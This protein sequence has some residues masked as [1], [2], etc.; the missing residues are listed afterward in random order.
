MC[1]Q[2]SESRGSSRAGSDG[3]ARRTSCCT[4]SRTCRTWKRAS[5]GAWVGRVHG[6]HGASSKWRRHEVSSNITSTGSR[7]SLEKPH[8]ADCAPPDDQA[9]RFQ[10]SSR[11]HIVRPSCIVRL[12]RQQRQGSPAAAAAGT[13]ASALQLRPIGR[14]RRST[15]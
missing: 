5:A 9:A 15:R 7:C 4:S 14:I 10:Q 2:R 8:D 11:R 3:Y 1:R 13:Q 12:R 6:C